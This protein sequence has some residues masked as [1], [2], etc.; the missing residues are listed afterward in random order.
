MHGD[1]LHA[2][3]TMSTSPEFSERQSDQ[4][5]EGSAALHNADTDRMATTHWWT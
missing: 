1:R 5:A 2:G 3:I 4:T